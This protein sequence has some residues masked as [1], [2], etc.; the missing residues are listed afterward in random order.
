MHR[1]PSSTHYKE[2]WLDWRGLARATQ[3]Y[4]V[5]YPNTGQER[6]QEMRAVILL[7]MEIASD[8]YVLLQIDSPDVVGVDINCGP[9]GWIRI[10]NIYNDCRHDQSLKAVD[11][12]LTGERESNDEARHD[13]M[14]W[15]G[16]FNR[17][18]PMWDEERNHHLFTPRNLEAAERL[19]DLA[20]Q[21]R[22]VMKLEKGVPTLQALNTKNHTRVDNIWC[23]EAMQGMVV[24]CDTEPEMR[25]PKTDHF[26]VVTELAYELIWNQEHYTEQRDKT[27]L[28]LLFTDDAA[29]VVTGAMFVD[30]HARIQE[31]M[32][33]RHG[34]FKWARN[35]NCE[36]GV[37]RF[38]LLDMSQ[39]KVP[40]PMCPRKRVPL[41]RRDLV[42]NRTRVASSKQRATVEPTGS[43]SI[44]KGEGLD[45]K[46]RKTGETVVWNNSKLRATEAQKAKGMRVQR[47]IV[48]KLTVAQCK[49]MI[50]VTGAM[51]TT[52]TDVM[53][54][55]TGSLPFHLVVER[56][57][58]QAALRLATLP[59][60]HPLHQHV[61]RAARQDVKGH[62]TPLHALMNGF[63]VDI[64]GVETVKATRWDVTWRSRL[65]MVIAGLRI[66]AVRVEEWDQTRVKIYT[67]GSG[68][69]GQV[70]AAAVM[71]RDGATTGILKMSL[72]AEKDCT[73]SGQR[74]YTSTIKQ[75]SQA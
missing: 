18:H 41:A 67:D 46:V 75:P 12:F 34:I 27:K 36:F 49:A 19:I 57:Q 54:A 44:G 73:E 31:I 62:Q 17:H 37:D 24:R 47:V 13:Q 66:E 40:H 63:K 48:R 8:H 56:H 53:E 26:P 64:Q 71:T 2:P 42:L 16:D 10:I 14:I 45:V 3:Q 1:T 51:C 72:G 61:K 11:D 22:M 68:Y 74:A 9:A 58:F 21:F 15:A 43:S 65:K 59:E 70:G 7:S 33:G 20:D 28:G 50:M 6:R 32:T 4:N 25:P 23:S 5:I 35:H 38:Q 39:K 29:I 52:A 55:L 69:K 60:G 30:T